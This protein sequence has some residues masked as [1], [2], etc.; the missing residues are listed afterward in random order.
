[1]SI[2]DEPGAAD[3]PH[4]E[5]GDELRN[6]MD[7]R[8]RKEVNEANVLLEWAVATGKK[9]DDQK[10]VDDELVKRIKEGYQWLTKD[11][12]PAEERAAFESAYKELTTI[13]APVTYRTLAATSDEHGRSTLL[14]PIYYLF[15]KKQRVSEARI[16][17]KKLWLWTIGL[18][19]TVMIAENFDDYL[20]VFAPADSQSINDADVGPFQRLSFWLSVILPFLYGALGACAYLLR[21]CHRFIHKRTFDPDRIPEY[22]N[23]GLLGFLAGGTILLFT[24]DD[25][26]LVGADTS[27][28]GAALAFLAGYST[29]FLYTT[30]E[31]VAAA[32]MPKQA[33]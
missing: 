16:W 8:F 1:M 17:S 23:R 32:V 15:H 10:S 6:E 19:L 20:D 18:L 9:L 11:E 22:F 25:G 26:T 12:I 7:A 24:T 33:Q 5:Q 30:L 31:R 27:L 21:S 29:D 28:T 4:Q 3:S 2:T 13:L 14:A